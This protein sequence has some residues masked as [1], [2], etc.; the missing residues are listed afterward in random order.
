MGQSSLWKNVEEP[1]ICKEFNTN[2]PRKKGHYTAT[3][4]KGS[5]DSLELLASSE[6]PS[7][8]ENPLFS[9]SALNLESNN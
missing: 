7:R 6:E 1:N 4:I 2:I 3:Q 5:L 9:G 8:K